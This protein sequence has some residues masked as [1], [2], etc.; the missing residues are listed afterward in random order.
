[1][2]GRTADRWLKGVSRSFYLSLRLLPC[3]MR[4]A[5]GL[6]YLLARTSDTL[7]DSSAA[8][9]EARLLCLDWFERLLAG[10]EAPPRWPLPVLLLVP[11]P[12]LLL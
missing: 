2:T 10:D 4:P 7:A 5:A 9:I 8:S 12:V 1:M 11:T 3:E 6:G